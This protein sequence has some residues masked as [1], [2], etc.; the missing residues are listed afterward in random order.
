MI[1][2]CT[3]TQ[4]YKCISFNNFFLYFII[5]FKISVSINQNIYNIYNP[6]CFPL[7]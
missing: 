7:T 6:A 1:T 2:L 5:L 3:T 4:T